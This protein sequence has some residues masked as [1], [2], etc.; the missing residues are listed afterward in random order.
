VATETYDSRPPISHR[1]PLYFSRTGITFPPRQSNGS[2]KEP[3][4]FPLSCP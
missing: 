1:R 2:P 4:G 3:E